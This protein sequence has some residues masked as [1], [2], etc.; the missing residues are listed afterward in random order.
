MATLNIK[1]FPDDLYSDLKERA[2]REHRSLTQEIIHLLTEA[3]ARPEPAS[4]LELRGLGKEIWKD[5]EA[6]EHVESERASWD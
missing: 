4:I 1:S 6:T 2:R 5:V 3:I